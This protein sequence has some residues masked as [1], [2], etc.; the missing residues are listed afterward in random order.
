MSG[1]KHICN[2]LKLLIIT[3]FD[4]LNNNEEVHLTDK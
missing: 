2:M 1:I 3:Y 4:N